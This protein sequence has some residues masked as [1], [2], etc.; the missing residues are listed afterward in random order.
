MTNPERTRVPGQI[1]TR[2]AG[3]GDR[4]KI[5]VGRHPHPSESNTRMW[6]ARPIEEN[7]WAT[8]ERKHALFYSHSD[9][10]A[11]TDA[12]AAGKRHHE[13]AQ[14]EFHTLHRTSGRAKQAARRTGYASR[15]I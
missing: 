8:P 15:E 6:Y 4:W 11:Y 2:V 14:R 1:P 5:T 13:V 9:A 3:L 7:V 12:R 10:T